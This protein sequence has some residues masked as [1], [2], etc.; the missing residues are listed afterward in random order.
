MSVVGILLVVVLVILV[1]GAAPFWPHSQ[2]YGYAPSGLLGVILLVLLILL[3]SG[4]L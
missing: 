2:G 4:R 1:L 3:L